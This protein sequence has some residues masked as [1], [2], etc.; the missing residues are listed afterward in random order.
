MDD[1]ASVIADVRG[2]LEGGGYVLE[3]RVAR[4]LARR[5]IGVDQ[6]FAYT[7]PETGK[8]REGDISA[9]IDV[10]TD[11]DHWHMLDLVIECKNTTAPWVGFHGEKWGNGPW[12]A[13]SYMDPKCDLCDAMLHAFQ[14]LRRTAPSVYALTEKRLRS[15]KTKDHAYE[16][17]RQV[18]SAMLGKYGESRWD[19]HPDTSVVT[20]LGVPVVVTQSPLI[21]CTL[22]DA[23]GVEL[24]SVDRMN[25]TVPRLDLPEAASDGMEVLVVREAA[26][27]S[28]VK[29]LE[30]L[31]DD[32]RVEYGRQ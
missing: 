21:M 12:T 29:E 9:M 14:E 18:S 2:W 15:A 5:H 30:T 24:A 19:G 13:G 25:V 32:W 17:V 7:D 27:D 4:A 31:T 3:M 6:G 28:L 26:F 22:G 1:E 23:G 11:D 10:D 16:S 8:E 20:V